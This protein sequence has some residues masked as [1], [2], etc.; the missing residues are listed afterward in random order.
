[1][2]RYDCPQCRCA[3]RTTAE[4]AQH[5]TSTVSRTESFNDGS[6]ILHTTRAHALHK[7]SR[8]LSHPPSASSIVLG[9]FETDPARMHTTT[10][11]S[12]A[13]KVDAHAHSCSSAS[14]HMCSIFA[15]SSAELDTFLR[16]GCMCQ[17][18]KHIRREAEAGLSNTSKCD[19]CDTCGDDSV[20]DQQDWCSR[21]VCGDHCPAADLAAPLSWM[22]K[23]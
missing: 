11:A 15:Y 12:M 16:S 13:I 2:D 8:L 4:C 6:L 10:A 14:T 22:A 21:C 18:H 5:A 3:C 19:V 9:M 1:M 17:Q 23:A 7:L 20:G